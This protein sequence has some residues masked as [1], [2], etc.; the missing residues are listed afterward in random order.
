MTADKD[1]PV[2]WSIAGNDTGGGAGLTADQRAADA[3]GVHLCPV[4]AALTAQN[5]RGV[6]DI[7]AVPYA[8]LQSQL[9]AL[10]DDLPPRV[11]KTGLLSNAQQVRLVAEWVDRLRQQGLL[12]LVVDPVLVASTGAPFA[13][14]ATLHAYRDL[15]LPRATL[16]TPNRREAGRLTDADDSV[17]VADL[18]ARL[19]QH[20]TAA[21]CITG[22]DDAAH[23]H[24]VAADW[25][26]APEAAGWLALPRLNTHHTHGTG[27]TFATS[28]AAALALGFVTAD[29]V[30]LAKMATAHALHHGYAAGQGAGPVWAQPGFGTEPELMPFLSWPDDADLPPWWQGVQARWAA[31]APQQELGLYALVDSAERIQQALAAGVR[32]LQLRIKTPH[33]PD[34]AW[35]AQL[36]QTVARSAALCQQA[37]ARLFINDHTALALEMGRSPADALGLHLGQEDLAALGVQGRIQVATSGLGLGV[38]SHSLWELA[39]ARSLDPVYIAC[40]PVWPTQTKEM[41]W[42]AQGIDNLAWWVHMAGCPVVAIGG[43]LQPAQIAQTAATGAGGLCVVRG[44]GDDLAVTVPALQQAIAE[45]S[46]RARAPVPALPHP[47]LP[48]RLRVGYVPYS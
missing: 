19:R 6:A 13:D 7:Y 17:S 43:I 47:S 39:R 9:A 48:N 38:S 42:R 15:L 46:A 27:C 41:P 37:G 30:V 21:V 20:G 35:Y 22:G 10:A 40:G 44:L 32:T 36:R 29:A 26:D 2:I 14:A 1:K 28:A 24:N 23:Q 12:A 34:D 18:A 45:G 33:E 25:L 5:S 3:F 11:I 31:P 4:V 16:L 8:Q